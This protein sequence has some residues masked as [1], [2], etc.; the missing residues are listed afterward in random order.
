MPEI[1]RAAFSGKDAIT[2]PEWATLSITSMGQQAVE[3]FLEAHGWD[4]RAAGVVGLKLSPDNSKVMAANLAL[5]G[6]WQ[7]EPM[8]IQAKKL[9]T[10]APENLSLE[11]TLNNLSIFRFAA[12]NMWSGFVAHW[13]GRGH[14]GGQP[15]STAQESSDHWIKFANW[16]SHHA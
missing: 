16:S 12:G 2:G 1:E 10:D 3:E 7:E 9:W 11:V 5:V 4:Q 13:S 6:N 14:S 15:P 8:H